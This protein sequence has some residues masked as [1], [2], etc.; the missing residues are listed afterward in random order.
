MQNQTP[1][2]ASITAMRE[3]ITL[4]PFVPFTKKR[5]SDPTQWVD[6]QGSSFRPLELENRP[7]VS[8]AAAAHYLHLAQQ[9]LRI[10]ACKENG[11]LRPRRINGRLHWV[12]AD[13]RKLLGVA[14]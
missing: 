9:T 4:E 11:P 13:I 6:E 3:A 10:Y 5:R 7:T 8:T 2:H 12:T 14:L 1:T